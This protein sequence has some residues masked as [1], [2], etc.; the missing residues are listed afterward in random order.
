MDLEYNKMSL[1]YEMSCDDKP[2]AL[3]QVYDCKTH[4]EFY[5]LISL[6]IMYKV[7]SFD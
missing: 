1:I 2:N 6:F 7:I 5:K 3:K 4:D